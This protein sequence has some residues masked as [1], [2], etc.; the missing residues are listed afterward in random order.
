MW[1]DGS[2]FAAPF[3]NGLLPS[4]VV[5]Q[6]HLALSLWSFVLMGVH[7]GL[8]FGIITSKIKGKPVKIA[9]GVLTGGVSVYGFYLFIKANFFD[10][11]LTVD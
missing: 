3:M 9:L 1:K 4:S 6:A 8:H 7:L 5:R 10:Y 2:R 11:M